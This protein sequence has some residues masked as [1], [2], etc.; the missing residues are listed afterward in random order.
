MPQALSFRR[1]Q[2]SPAV[3]FLDD[4]WL[5]RVM[6]S[7]DAIEHGYRV[8]RAWAAALECIPAELLGGILSPPNA[9][10][11][12][13]LHM[14]NDALAHHAFDRKARGLP[15]ALGVFRDALEA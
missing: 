10:T 12:E 3:F 11:E 14:L 8:S 9:N 7:P 4:F 13:T 2:E 6:D 1:C 15:H 5:R